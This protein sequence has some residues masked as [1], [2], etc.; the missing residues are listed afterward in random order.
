MCP[1]K[2]PKIEKADP[3]AAPPPPMD[4]PQAPVLNEATQGKTTDASKANTAR[5][6][7]SSLI[8][9]LIQSPGPVGINIP[10]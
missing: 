1:P 7:R 2:Q 10:R 6:G 8:I 5:R 4:A 9:P 3:V